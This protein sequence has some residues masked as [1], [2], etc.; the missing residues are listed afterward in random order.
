VAWSC[1]A[2]QSPEHYCAGCTYSTDYRRSYR[3]EKSVCS[4]HRYRSHNMHAA[5][6]RL[7][8]ST[9]GSPTF[10]SETERR[11][12]RHCCRLPSSRARPVR[13]PAAFHARPLLGRRRGAAHR[14]NMVLQFVGS[15][16]HAAT[17][18]DTST[19]LLGD[20]E[21]VEQQEHEW[22]APAPVRSRFCFWPRSSRPPVDPGPG[23]G[24]GQAE[25]EKKGRRARSPGQRRAS[26]CGE[27][28]QIPGAGR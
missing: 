11:R 6:C 26:I 9:A 10:A 19:L 2:I 23:R 21:I 25:R 8:R 18:A 3:P 15:L 5:E 14:E 4:I 27:R 22:A 20:R 13:V 24:G 7:V 28:W 17:H 12:R 1:S 16:L